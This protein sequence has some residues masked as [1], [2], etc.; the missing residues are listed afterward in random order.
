MFSLPPVFRYCSLLAASSVA[1]SGCHVGGPS[2]IRP[3]PLLPFA[4]CISQ[5]GVVLYG[6]DWCPHC[7]QQKLMFGSAISAVAYVECPQDPQRCLKAGIA[8][9]PTWVLPDGSKLEGTQPLED[10]AAATGCQLP[11]QP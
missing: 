9:Y 2:A 6:A 3:S 11:Q 8:G 10:L 5:R 7:Q 4:Q 1:L